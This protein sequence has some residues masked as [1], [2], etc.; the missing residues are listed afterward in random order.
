MVEAP[1]QE[2]TS[3]TLL[4]WT[5][6]HWVYTTSVCNYK[7]YSA[8]MD[9]TSFNVT[10]FIQPAFVYE[11]LNLVPDADGLNDRQLFDFPPERELHLDELKVR[12]ASDTPDL[13]SLFSAVYDHH[14]TGLVEYHLQGEAFKL[15]EKTHDEL[16]DLKINTKNENAR[17]PLKSKRILCKDRDGY[18]LPALERIDIGENVQLWE[19]S[20][21]PKAVEAA[22]AI[23]HHLNHQKFE[24]L[25]I[26]PTDNNLIANKQN[27]AAIVSGMAL[28]RW[29]HHT[30]RSV[31]KTHQ[32]EGWGKLPIIEGSRYSA[33]G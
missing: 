26:D 29:H 8:S 9:L 17:D 2:I 31:S 27:D 23:T 12:M 16:V 1:G 15:Y 20:V 24:M 21:T 33:T 22:A 14:T 3:P 13:L 7:S 32:R 4:A 28:K 6:C 19:S 11:M 30:C 5:Q 10:G 18:S 25:G